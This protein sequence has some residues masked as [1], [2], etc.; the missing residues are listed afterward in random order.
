[1]P[2][3]HKIKTLLLSVILIFSATA[4]QAVSLIRDAE[5]EDTLRAY[6][7][8]IFREAGLNPS[9]IHIFIVNDPTLNAFVAGGANMFIHTGLIMKMETPS[10]LIGVIAHETGHIAGG[11]LAQGAEKIKDAQ[12]GTVLSMVLG[13]AVVASG[14]ADAGMAIMSAGQEVAMRN[15]LRFTRSN[16]SA[17][18]QAAL[19][20]LD[21][22]NITADGFLK[23][24]ELLR[25]NDNRSFGTP[26]PYTRTHPLSIDRISHIR[27]HVMQSKLTENSV[28][29][30][31]NERHARMIAKLVGF[32]QPLEETLSL[33]PESDT[34]VAAR[35]ARAI[36]YYRKA[37]LAKALSEIDP[38]LKQKP[39]D[40]FLH[41]LRGQFLFENGRIAESIQSYS[42]A[43]ALKPDSALI[44]TDYGRAL[45]ASSQKDDLAKATKA[46]EHASTLDNSNVNTWHMLAIAYGKSDRQGQF[47]LASAEEAMLTN[48][49]DEAIRYAG[50][51]LQDKSLSNG[52]R[53]RAGDIKLEAEKARE[54]QKRLKR[55]PF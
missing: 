39:N 24:L 23:T 51:A 5:I 41:E 53:L 35:Y 10:M 11:H 15:F 9:S 47:N 21:G 25:Q 30:G 54:E 42:K 55:S 52:A 26:D 34:S 3:R 48:N 20:Y 6:S 36:A 2:L 28:P 14:G 1:M 18:D 46:L 19:N 4:A 45:L 31:F 32:I 29:K 22:L 17:A 16:E 12:L 8:P 50:A 40:P 27:D 13:A 49:M 44:L 33:Y 37:D 7:N 38:L 43:V